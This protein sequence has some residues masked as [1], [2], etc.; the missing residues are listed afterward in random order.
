VST[1]DTLKHDSAV[2]YAGR[3]ND[4]TL[5][6]PEKYNGLGYDNLHSMEFDHM[7]LSDSWRRGGKRRQTQDALDTVE[8]LHLVLVEEP[9]AHLHMQV[10]QVFIRKA[11]SVLR[12]HKFLKE[13]MNFATQLVISAHSS[14]IAR[15]T[16]FADLRYFKRLPECA[17]CNVATAKV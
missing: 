3:K 12:K 6:L 5:K 1:G 8:P 16:D 2:Q 7:R 13:N 4:A 17:N 10:Q 14:H 9:E 11:Y 15:E